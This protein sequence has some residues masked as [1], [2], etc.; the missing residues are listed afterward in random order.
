MLAPQTIRPN[1]PYSRSHAWVHKKL[2]QPHHKTNF[3]DGN[4][5]SS[6]WQRTAH[7]IAHT[8]SSFPGHSM[9]LECPAHLKKT[10][11][12][13]EQRIKEEYHHT[14][15]FRSPA[16]YQAMAQKTLNSI[17][18][19]EGY[20]TSNHSYPALPDVSLDLRDPLHAYLH[21]LLSIT[22]EIMQIQRNSPEHNAVSLDWQ[23]NRYCQSIKTVLTSPYQKT[24]IS[25]SICWY[26]C[27]D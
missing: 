1:I 26:I 13:E 3:S 7:L 24:D 18:P 8:P 2:T 10:T 19:E 20:I 11:S 4:A 25:R 14:P 22:G 17:F 6:L 21:T 16:Y 15:N 23:W 27:P 9:D 12:N 5:T